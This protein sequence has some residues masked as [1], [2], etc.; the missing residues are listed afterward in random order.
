MVGISK[1]SSGISELSHPTYPYYP[2]GRFFNFIQPGFYPVPFRFPSGPKGLFGQS[3]GFMNIFGESAYIPPS[4]R[5]LIFT[6]PKRKAVLIMY[7][8]CQIN[9]NLLGQ[10]HQ[11]DTEAEAIAL[12]KRIIG[13]NGVELTPDVLKEVE[14]SLSYLDESKEWSV[15]IGIVEA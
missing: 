4:S 6:T 13:E 7:F 9:N 11:C 2:W 14:N 12:V 10:M 8:V 5:I 3:G 15:C 1:L